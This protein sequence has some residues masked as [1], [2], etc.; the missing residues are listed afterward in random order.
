M[1]SQGRPV[2]GAR[3]SLTD[4]EE[5]LVSQ[6][7]TEPT[8]HFAFTDLPHGLYWVTAR[9]EDDAVDTAT[10]RHV[11]LTPE[12]PHSAIEIFLL[13]QPAVE[14]K[15]WLHKPV[16]FRVTDSSGAPAGKVL[17][18]SVWSIGTALD[19]AEAQVDEHG[20]A[21]MELIPGNNF[22]TLKKRGCPKEE[23]R[24]EVEKGDGIDAFKL[25]LEC[26]PP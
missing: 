20:A 13:P 14:A 11:T 19:T 8:G 15:Q 18:Q 12:S 17:I 24:V 2:P 4:S 21:A 1:D 6:L 3:V 22:V 16:L 9:R 23:Y 10:F 5:R 7:V 26:T 25:T